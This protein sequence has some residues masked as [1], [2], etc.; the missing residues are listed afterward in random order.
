MK[1]TIGKILKKWRTQARYSQLKLAI[2][3][4]VSSKHIS[5]IET[6]RSLPSKEMILKI[7]EFLQV[8]KGEIN[9]TLNIAGYAPTIKGTPIILLFSYWSHRVYKR[10]THNFIS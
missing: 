5:F 3:L 9:R 7:C 8:P 4:D 6:G 1:N 10:D 2:E